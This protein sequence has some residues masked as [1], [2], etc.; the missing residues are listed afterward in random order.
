M[1][2]LKELVLKN[3]QSKLDEYL[4]KEITEQLDKLD[5][6]FD[7]VCKYLDMMYDIFK[8]V[9]IRRVAIEACER[10]NLM[11]HRYIRR[12][13]VELHR[14]ANIVDY[15]ENYDGKLFDNHCLEI[16][17]YEMN[18]L[19]HKNMMDSLLYDYRWWTGYVA[20][21]RILIDELRFDGDR[22]FRMIGEHRIYALREECA[23]AIAEYYLG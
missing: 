15:E 23:N 1:L 9:L 6:N 4:S 2:S 22:V 19:C 5:D 10:D 18:I 14:E 7:N 16:L 13:F 3:H 17:E 20:C 11:C 8:D 12:H 21:L